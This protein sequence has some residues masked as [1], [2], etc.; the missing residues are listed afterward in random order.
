MKQQKLI[1]FVLA[2]LMFLFVPMVNREIGAEAHADDSYASNQIAVNGPNEP[3]QNSAYIIFSEKAQMDG[4]S[5][6]EPNGAGRYDELYSEQAE[7]KGISCRQVYVQNYLYLKTNEEF[8]TEE[9]CVFELTFDYWDYGGGG[10]FYVEY[11]PRGAAEYKSLRVLKL[12]LDEDGQKTDG[13]WFRVTIYIDDACFKGNMPYGADFRIRSGAYNAFSKIEVR[14]LSQNATD[15]EFG[16]FNMQKAHSLHTLG[17]FDGFSGDINENGE[18]SP[19]LTREL[20][21][22]EAIVEMVKCYGLEEEAKEKNIRPTF[23]DVSTEALPY[24]GLMQSYG[25][26]KEAQTLGANDT[27]TQKELVSMY[28]KLFGESDE[29]IEKDPYGIARKHGLISTDSMIFQPDK[30]ATTDAFVALA[31]NIFAIDNLRD[32]YNPFTS[33]FEKGIYTEQTIQDAKDANISNWLLNNTFNLKYKTIVDEYSGRTYHKIDFLG[34]SA[35][36]EYYTQNC[37]STDNE[38]L[39]FSTDD[40]SIFEYNI[41]TQKCRY[42]GKQ[43]RRWNQLVTPKNNLWYLNYKGEIIKVDLD[44]YEQTKVAELPPWQKNSAPTLMQV[45]HAETKASFQWQDARGEFD[46]NVKSRIPVVDLT[47]GEWDLSNVFGFPTEWLHLAHQCIN[48]VYDQYVFFAHEGSSPNVKI[49]KDIAPQYDRLWVLN[50]DTDEYYN[51]FKQKWF[52]QPV[53]NDPTT[54]FTGEGSV[55]EAWSNDGEW[56]MIVKNKNVADALN[57]TIGFGSLVIMRPDGSEKRYI[58]ADYSFTH[59][60]GDPKGNINHC[61]MSNNNRWTASDSDYNQGFSD[62]YLIDNYTGQT[63]FLA[64]LNQRGDDPGHIHPQFSPDDQKVIFGLWGDDNTYSEIGWMDVSDIVNNPAQGGEYELSDSCRTFS[65]EGADSYMEVLKGE[66]EDISG[67]KIPAGNKMYVDV[68]KDVIEADNTP[69]EI[70]VTYKDDSILPIKLSYYMW[71]V[72]SNDDN[73][74]LTNCIQ[75]IERKGTG[76]ILTKTFK[77][78]DICLGNMEILGSDF[79]LSAIGADATVLSVD[80]VI[81]KGDGESK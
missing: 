78:K 4:M 54:G 17:V 24:V 49:G 41:R 67:F 77:M 48:P 26:V 73:N 74:S 23:T 18:F 2:A 59:N 13:T 75:Y 57:R 51:A 70:T 32:K 50:R 1:C 3:E 79:T 30:L 20:T 35:C 61:M 66:S 56:L 14:N 28:L 9:D 80:V 43:M 76:K 11:L 52:I 8:A 45:N 46:P 42:I 7:F 47:T 39:F 29:N 36:K 68:K 6:I 12:G 81:P 62:L 72:R 63:Y 58:P 31:V 64:R 27:F 69:A 15:E 65:Y 22:E 25:V 55:H 53:N 16:P 19:N 37:M 10:Y 33:Y 60:H 34:S 5:Y 44:T 21:R 40:L 71:Q 38:R